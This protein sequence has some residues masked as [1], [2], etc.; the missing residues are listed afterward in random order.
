M[1]AARETGDLA[2]VRDA[3][4][5]EGE[6]W[7]HFALDMRISGFDPFRFND[8]GSTTAM[9][10][11]MEPL[12]E[13]HYADR[14]YRLAAGLAEVPTVSGDGLVHTF[15]ISGALFYD[16]WPDPLWE[17]RTREVTARDVVG[18]ILRHADPHVNSAG[19]WTLE[20]LIEGLDV[21]R[22]AAGR[23]TPGS[24][25]LNRHYAAG[26]AGG[27]AGLRVADDRTVVFRLT[28]ADPRFHQ[29]LAL[30]YHS[31]LPWEMT[32]EGMGNLANRPVG[33]GAFYVADWR[34]PTRVAFR[35]SPAR[36]GSTSP[37]L[38]GATLEAVVENQPRWLLFLDGAIDAAAPDRD[39]FATAVT[40]AGALG[41][42]LALRGV[43]L[44]TSRG[45]DVTFLGFNMRDPVVGHLPGD[46]EGNR[47]RR[48]LRRAIALAYPW[49]RWFD[50]VRNGAWAVRARNCLPP[51]L[52]EAAA[53]P[54][55]EWTSGPDLGRAAALLAEAGWPDGRGLP[56]L[57]LEE[58]GTGSASRTASLLLKDALAK[59]GIRITPTANT[60]PQF[61]AK[62][63][64]SSAQ[65]F[66][67]AWRLDYPDAENV[68][69]QFYGPNASPG[70][71]AVNFENAAY[72][73]LFER[74]RRLPPGK[75]RD[76]V[77]AEMVGLLNA[78]MPWA[79]R[80]HR[81]GYHAA[82][83]WLEGYRPHALDPLW[84]EFLAVDSRVKADTMAAWGQD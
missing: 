48:L 41:A 2:P 12:L 74:F 55:G 73:R 77:A 13:F 21:W 50:V 69:M 42:E 6:S 70:P 7:A 3:V 75:E 66:R 40:P 83:A 11:V 61:D 26:A 31:V 56:V 35:R 59:I 4:E 19:W 79:P 1:D 43:T 76:D 10:Q 45:L 53:A 37:A 23:M 64:G 47:R 80:D 17:G 39:S 34:P 54:A 71:N 20:G 14:P 78:E 24:R 82:H 68:L 84:L 8:R 63:K 67:M 29:V 28:R 18:G 57:T 32:V 58:A 16:P 52:R 22:A 60:W 9:H 33:T 25:E 51:G 38:D 36:R 72:D 49:D 5:R 81:L 62:V 65:M 46:E 27:V 15:R 44:Q 30:K